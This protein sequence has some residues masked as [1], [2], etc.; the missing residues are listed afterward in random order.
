MRTLALTPPVPKTAVPNTAGR[1]R[2]VLR[3]A[4]LPLLLVLSLGACDRLRGAFGGTEG[5]PPVA[6]PPPAAAPVV[7]PQGARTAAAFDRTTEADK[8]AAR[9]VAATGAEL[10]KLVVSLG[11]PAEQGF[12]LRSALVKAAR[13]GVVRLASG[14]S[15]QVDLLPATGGGPQLS[16]AAYRALGLGLTDLPTVTVLTR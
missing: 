11:N 12:W 15:V 3:P 8:Q 9:A 13:P 2:A 1:Q 10:G 16:L 4:V 5:A 6:A 7:A 14:A